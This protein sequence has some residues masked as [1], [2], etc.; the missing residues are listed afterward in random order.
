MVTPRPLISAAPSSSAEFNDLSFVMSKKNKSEAGRILEFAALVIS[1]REDCSEVIAGLSLPKERP[2]KL[3]K[4]AQELRTDGA[5]SVARPQKLA[6]RL[7]FA[8]SRLWCALE[9]QVRS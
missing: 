7:G 3:V 2:E 1:F 5:A 9:W 4:L 8:Q 6:G